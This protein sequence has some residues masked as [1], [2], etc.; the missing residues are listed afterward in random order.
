M[1]SAAVPR[2]HFDVCEGGYTIPDLGGLE[3]PNVEAAREEAAKAAAELSK[4]RAARKAPVADA[5]IVVRPSDS[6]EPIFTVP[7]PDRAH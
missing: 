3:L 7:V 6:L 1:R 4:E 2:F 5:S